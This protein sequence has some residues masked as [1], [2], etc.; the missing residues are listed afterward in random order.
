MEMVEIIKTILWYGSFVFVFLL[1]TSVLMNGLRSLYKMLGSDDMRGMLTEMG[2]TDDAPKN[3][4]SRTAGAVGAF[5]LAS[6]FIGI[7]YWIVYILF[8][9]D[10]AQLKDLKDLGIYFLSGSALFAPYAFNQM[11]TIFKS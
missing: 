1:M 10:I 7:G 11:K 4:F 5:G 9:G 8:L 6:V 2:A 3:S